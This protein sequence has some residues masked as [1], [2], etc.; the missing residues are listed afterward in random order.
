VLEEDQILTQVK[1]GNR[2]AFAR[3]IEYYELPIQRYLYR[4]TE[5][6]ETARDLTQDTFL[7]AYKDI[8]KNSNVRE[9][10]AWLYRIA[11]NKAIDY[12]RRKKLLS[13]IMFNQ[14]RKIEHSNDKMSADHIF[15]DIEI[16]E[17]FLEVPQGLRAC[18]ELYFVE[19][20]KY[21]DIGKII[22]ISQDAVRKR[23][24][25]GRKIFIEYIAEKGEM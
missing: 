11:T 10:R 17:A 14:S 4:L 18:L 24:A 6:Y 1:N 25:R 15:E 23:V 16:N 5:D 9:F 19:G 12:R 3:I 21:R 20:F 7:Q 8:L 2:E 13:F 22:G